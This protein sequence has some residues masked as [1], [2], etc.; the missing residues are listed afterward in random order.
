MAN[1]MQLRKAM[2][3][4]AK[5]VYGMQ[6]WEGREMAYRPRNKHDRKPW[7]LARDGGPFR[8]G[9]GELEIEWGPEGEPVE[10]T[11]IQEH[12]L[13]ALAGR[14][15]GV[16]FPG[17]GWHWNN[18]STTIRFLLGLV[19]KGLAVQTSDQ[20]YR[21]RFEITEKGR[22]LAAPKFPTPP[23]EDVD[24]VL[25]MLAEHDGGWAPGCGWHLKSE[26]YVTL[27]LKALVRRGYAVENADGS[28]G[29][30]GTAYGRARELG[31]D[32]NL[33]DGE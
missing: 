14:N 9:S 4:G 1:T 28:F 3:K 25:V 13:R 12:M 30:L 32:P 19:K 5:I 23:Q 7:V 22:R 15:G 26:G 31:Y 21:E 24:T 16:W 33:V 29:M 18:R 6:P 10:L 8:F 11:E 27:C 17:C 20:P 2:A